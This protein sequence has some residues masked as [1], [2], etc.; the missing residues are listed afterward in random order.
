MRPSTSFVDWLMRYLQMT[1]PMGAAPEAL[2][3]LEVLQSNQR[4]PL[5]QR[6]EYAAMLQAIQARAQQ[7]PPPRAIA[8]SELPR[9]L[10]QWGSAEPARQEQSLRLHRQLHPAALCAGATSDPARHGA[11]TWWWRIEGD[12]TWRTTRSAYRD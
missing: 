6:P 5:S 1:E 11:D 10:A 9:L 4:Q 8:E 2:R 3:L 7:A 12:V